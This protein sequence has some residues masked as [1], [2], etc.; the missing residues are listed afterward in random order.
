MSLRAAG[1]QRAVPNRGFRPNRVPCA[2]MAARR[3]GRG[4]ERCRP[5]PRSPPNREMQQKTCRLSP[6][7]KSPS[8]PV[9]EGD[10]RPF[11]RTT[12]M[13]AYHRVSQQ[14]SP[15]SR[16]HR[17]SLGWR[18]RT[19]EVDRVGVCATGGHCT[20]DAAPKVEI[21]APE[22]PNSGALMPASSAEA[23]PERPGAPSFQMP[24]HRAHPAQPGARRGIA[25][26]RRSH[27]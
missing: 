1:S 9:S 26:S 21:G 23:Q 12:I 20:H 4:G 16:R 5:K 7:R 6:Y 2:I 10:Y 18:R 27:S 11:S 13:T 8:R 19:R 14:R 24:G 15:A 25:G 22:Q 3:C 17:P